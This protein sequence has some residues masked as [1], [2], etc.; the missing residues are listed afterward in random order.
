MI[1]HIYRSKLDIENL[2]RLKTNVY[3]DVD[4]FDYKKIVVNKPWGY[5]YLMFENQFVA[6]WILFIKSGFSTSMHCHPSKKTSLVVLSGKAICNTLQGPIKRKDK[7]GLLIDEG[8]FHSTKAVSKD[9]AFVMEMEAPPNKK[10]LVRLKDEYGRENKGYE[11][12][13]EMSIKIGKY[14]YIDFHDF[15]FKKK[16]TK[17]LK[18]SKLSIIAN[19]KPSLI[20]KAL[21][22]LSGMVCL[23]EGK[24]HDSKGDV[25][26]SVGEA[27]TIEKFKLNSTISITNDIILLI[28]TNNE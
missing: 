26:L 2:S 24:I 3:K 25:L 18:K 5:E 19:K 14:E 16:I 22:S 12:K 9:G 7:E 27:C 11:G 6:I 13:N 21:G 10:D 8:V 15:D 28:V 20:K 1:K 17:I 23:L 4:E